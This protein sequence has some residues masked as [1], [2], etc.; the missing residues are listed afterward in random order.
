MTVQAASFPGAVRRPVLFVGH[1]TPL[2][3]LDDNVYTRAWEDIGAK[4]GRPRVILSVSAHWYTRGTGVTAMEQPRTIYDF[5]YT[6]MFHVSYPAPGSPEFAR[7]VA[8]R[9]APRAHAVLDDSVWGLDHGTWAVLAKMFPRADIPV[10]QLSIDADLTG[11]D[12]Y[13]LGRLLAPLRDEDVQIICSGNIVHNLRH[14]VRQGEGVPYPWATRFDEAVREHLERR[15]WEPLLDYLALD[16]SAALASPTPDHYLPLLY[17][18]GAAD[19]A[20]PLS[21]PVEGIDRGSMSMRSV[22]FGSY[23]TQG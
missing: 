8:Q 7:E 19:P 10:V 1:G 15:D 23:P 17:A 2:N 18:L 13:E 20:E 5:G 6:N 16:E 14:I 21:F 22:L 12:H 4:L 9:L 11:Q 3:V